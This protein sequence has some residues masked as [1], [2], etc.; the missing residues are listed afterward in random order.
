MMTD[1]PSVIFDASRGVGTIHLN[2]PRALNAL[3]L[4][5]CAAIQRQLGIWAADNTIRLVVVT[6]EGERAFCAGGDV[7]WVYECAQRDP[8][9]A[10]RFF[11]AEYAMD[12][13][14]ARYPKPYVSLIDGIAMGG[15]LGLS[16]NGRFRVVTENVLAAMPET[17]I[18][19][20]PDVG[21][22]TFLNSCPG[23]TGLYLGLTGTRLDAADAL[24]TGLATHFVPHTRLDELVEAFASM[25]PGEDVPT[26]V[27]ATLQQFAET[28]GSSAL[29]SQQEEIDRIFEADTVEDILSRLDAA[30]TPFSAAAAKALRQR[31]PT[32]LKITVR[33][34]RGYPDLT[35]DQSLVLEYRVISHIL[36]RHDFFEGVRAVVIDKTGEPRWKPETLDVV[37]EADVEAHFMPLA[38][39][40]LVLQRPD[41][42]GP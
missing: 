12:W 22:T 31:S 2:R 20:I 29:A 19:L 37:R 27:E 24:Y 7:R 1:S 36:E 25:D 39:A 15:G 28:P 21:A 40:E 18:G 13:T 3:T 23:H 4:E 10:L 6:G 42:G 5:M 34:L 30:T 38:D 17:G 16:V 33:Q 26:S 11:A 9:S 32:S 41:H 8:V 14:I 35:V